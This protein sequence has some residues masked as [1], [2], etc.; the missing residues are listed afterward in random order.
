MV[1]CVGVCN[2][3]SEFKLCWLMFGVRGGYGLGVELEE[4]VGGGYLENLRDSR[5][6]IVCMKPCTPVVG[7]MR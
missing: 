2:L 6:P 5:A 4:G 7:I 1:C 3:L